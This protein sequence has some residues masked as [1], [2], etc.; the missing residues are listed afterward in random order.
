L[1]TLRLDGPIGNCRISV[2]V[3]SAEIRRRLASGPSV[4]VTDPNVRGLHGALF[5]EANVIEIGSGERAKELRTVER[6][7]RRFRDL[8][9]DRS[10][11]VWGVGGGV[12][13]DVAGFAASTYLRGLPFGFVP[14]TL[15]AQIDA[16]IGGKNGVNLDGDK[17]LVGAFRQPRCVLLNFDVLR[18]LSKNDVLCGLAEIVKYGL[19]RSASFF[20]FLETHWSGLRALERQAL[21]TAVV[22]SV[23]IKAGIVR[24]DAEESGERKLLN[25]G[26]TLGHAVEKAAGLPHGQAVAVGMAFAV[27]LSLAKG[28]LNEAAA[29][30]AERLLSRLHAPSADIPDPARLLKSIRKDKKR[31]GSGLDFVLL[32]K[33]GQARIV[34]LPLRELEDAVHDLREHR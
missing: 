19:I 14:T 31:R 7:Y 30:R 16:A 9:V 4:I 28:L 13:C 3:P 33:I 6:I 29:R 1:K 22:E 15:L 20:R 26:H 34:N 5:P 11:F 10:T 12:V 18:T 32:E 2:D 27:R 25:F 24:R 17:N 23:R 21:R 8:E